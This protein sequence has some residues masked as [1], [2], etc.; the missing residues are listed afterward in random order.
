MLPNKPSTI[1]AAMLATWITCFLPVVVVDVLIGLNTGWIQFGYPT[2]GW[3]VPYTVVI[4]VVGLAYGVPVYLLLRR[5]DLNNYGYFALAGAVP[6]LTL[7]VGWADMAVFLS[8]FGA[9]VAVVFRF[10]IVRVGSKLSYMDSLRK[11]P[12]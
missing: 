7:V 5:T 11:R 6:G 2:L 12:Q 1:L 10:T 3:F 4:A 8:A 9:F